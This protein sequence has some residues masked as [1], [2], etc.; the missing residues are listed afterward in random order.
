MKSLDIMD[1]AVRSSELYV[2]IISLSL[3]LVKSILGNLDGV[4]NL[5]HVDADSINGFQEAC[6]FF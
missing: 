6:S 2:S 4:H 5:L 3:I 1:W